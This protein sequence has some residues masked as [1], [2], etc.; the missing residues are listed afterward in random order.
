M[1]TAISKLVTMDAKDENNKET[2]LNDTA[3]EEDTGLTLT[4]ILEQEDQLEED[5]DAVL[6]PS[7]DKNCSFHLV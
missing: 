1:L 4:E 6:G 3:D 7:D 5:C 2:L